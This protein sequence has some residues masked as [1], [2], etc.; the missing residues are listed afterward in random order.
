MDDGK[1]RE[2]ILDGLQQS[3]RDAAAY[4]FT[5]FCN[6]DSDTPQSEGD[7][8]QQVFSETLERIVVKAQ[9]AVQVWKDGQT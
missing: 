1:I 4:A 3:I 6:S 7:K 8:S 2:A 5:E 9:I